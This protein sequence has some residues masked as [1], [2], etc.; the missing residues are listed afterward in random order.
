MIKIGERTMTWLELITK[1]RKT[2]GEIYVLSSSGGAE[3]YV[4]EG[5]GW[6]KS[7]FEEESQGY[8]KDG[9]VSSEEL[10]EKLREEAIK[11]ETVKV[12]FY[13]GDVFPVGETGEMVHIYNPCCIISFSRF[14]D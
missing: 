5:D 12:M 13:Y 2:G 11:G 7:H 1:W 3:R 9:Y 4:P 8:I 14:R 10:A 6:V